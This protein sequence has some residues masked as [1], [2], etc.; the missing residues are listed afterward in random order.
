ML[1]R[2][3]HPG[4]EMAPGVEQDCERKGGVRS[5]NP[6]DRGSCQL[7]QGGNPLRIRRDENGNRDRRREPELLHQRA[8]LDLAVL[9]FPLW[10]LFLQPLGGEIARRF[11]RRFEGPEV[12][13]AGDVLDYRCLGRWI[14]GCLQNSRS[15]PQRLLDG[16]D[17]ARAVHALNLQAQRVAT[18]SVA[19]RLDPLDDISHASLRRLEGYIDGFSRDVHPRLTYAIHMY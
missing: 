3:D 15:P 12:R 8:I 1:E 18:H 13:G 9:A 19:S 10:R 7:G 16:R 17:A 6:A 5:P 2:R 14:D 4:Q 11:D